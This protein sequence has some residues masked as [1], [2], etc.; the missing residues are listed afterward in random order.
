VLWLKFE[1]GLEGEVDLQRELDGEV[2]APLRNPTV[3]RRFRL[4]PMLKT[5]VWPGGA[6]FA[7]EFLRGK[8]RVD[9]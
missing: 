3:F 5:I 7:P 6:D 8:L 4:D 1:D 9:A 2:F